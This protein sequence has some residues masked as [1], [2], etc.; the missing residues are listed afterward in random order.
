M[1]ACGYTKSELVNKVVAKGLLTKSKA[2][3]SN[4]KELCKLITREDMKLK[5]L[6][7]RVL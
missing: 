5:E 1:K 6:K 7:G 2:Q 3:K 4:M